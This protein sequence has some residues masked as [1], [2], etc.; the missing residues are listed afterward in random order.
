MQRYLGWRVLLVVV[1]SVVALLAVVPSTPWY[2]AGE[3]GARTWP[4]KKAVK[5]GLDLKG[6]MHLILSINVDEAIENDISND[7][8]DIRREARRKDIELSKIRRDPEDHAVTFTLPD[9]ETKQRLDDLVERMYGSLPWD[10]GETSPTALRLVRPDD[11]QMGVTRNVV[12]Q[13][14]EK[15]RARVDESGLA[16]ASIQARGET[17]LLVQL[18]GFEDRQRA[19]ALIGK[20]ARLDFRVAKNL[21]ETMAVIREADDALNGKLMARLVSRPGADPWLIIPRDDVDAVREL[22][23]SPEARAALPD[24]YIYATGKLLKEDDQAFQGLYVME[25]HAEVGGDDLSKAWRNIQGMQ[26]VVM[27]K[28]R[29]RGAYEFERL[30]GRIVGEPLAIVLDGVVQSAPTVRDEISRRS[31]GYIHGQF[32]EQEADDL[33]AMLRAG[34]L[35]AT[36]NIEEERV[37]TASLGQDSINRSLRAIIW[38]GLA[39]VAFMVIYY[40]MGGAIADIALALNLV[41]IIAVLAGLGAA[42]SLPG[43]AGIILTVGMAVDANVLIFERMREEARAGKTFRA[44]IDAAYRRAGVTIL[45]ANVTTLIAAFVLFQFTTGPVQGFA[46]TLSIGVVTSMFTALVVTRLIMDLLERSRVVKGVPML[47][48]IG[49]PKI[50]FIGV[51]HVAFAVSGVLIVAG[52]VTFAGRAR[53]MF[54]V[55]FRGGTLVQRAFTV[56]V[57]LDDIRASLADAGLAKSMIQRFAMDDGGTGVI[58]RA[59]LEAADADYAATAD[60]IDAALAASFGNDFRDPAEYGQTDTVGPS[61]GKELAGDAMLAM[62]CALLGIVAYISWR[63]EF[64]F[65]IAA[66]I[67]L[68][69]D[70]LITLGAFAVTGREINLP[71]V[72]ALLTIVGYSL[73]DTI[74]VFD[75]IREDVKLMRRQSFADIVNISINQTLSRTVLTSVTTLIVVL[76]LFVFGGES[77]KDFAFALL[78]GVVVGTYSSIFVA[79][80]VLVEWR[81]RTRA[82]RRETAKVAAAESRA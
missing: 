21:E 40:L 63:F 56:D 69:H 64:K 8:E 78:I 79:S 51:R 80:P 6:G 26:H 59:P 30:T 75:R 23:D 14:I 65:A 50:P 70:V 5:Y 42:L 54:G 37:V 66:I 34:A 31:I 61:V 28:F 52:V 82:G 15:I 35:P 25:E 60:H 71:V 13:A 39:V 19:R 44:V 49:Q 18:P 48:L 33:A 1:V 41:I 2:R 17:E 77:I 4:F 47:R 3:G 67:A 55:D 11:Y 81:T 72:A 29:S 9:A 38:G 32:T 57:A 36:I 62:G 22:L 12:G 27:L 76:S 53:G 7:V 46:T 45:D 16:E 43:I 74:V 10:R 68:V 58:I 73:N 24:E 20:T